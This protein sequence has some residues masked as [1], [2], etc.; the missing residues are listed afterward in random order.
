MTP[1]S[2]SLHTLDYRIDH[3]ELGDLALNPLTAEFT[4]AWDAFEGKVRRR[5]QRDGTAEVLQPGHRA[6]GRRGAAVRLF[7]T[8]PGGQQTDHGVTALLALRR[9]PSIPVPCGYHRPGVRA[10]APRRRSGRHAGPA[11]HGNDAAH[12]PVAKYITYADRTVRAPGSRSTR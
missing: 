8:G 12:E 10:P 3:A 5:A 1:P 11:P 9:C 6:D 2:G 4:A 7:P